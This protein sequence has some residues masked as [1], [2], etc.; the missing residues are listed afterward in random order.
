[1]SDRIEERDPRAANGRGGVINPQAS[2]AGYAPYQMYLQPAFAGMKGDSSEDQVDTFACSD[3]P[4]PFGVVVG[5]TAPH[6]LT[7][8]PGGPDLVGVA[9]HD[10]IIASRGGY[11]Q[12]DAVSVMT[13]GRVWCQV[14]DDAGADAIDDGIYVMY[15]PTNG[16]VSSTA[17]TVV[18]NAV[19]KGKAIDV[20]DITYTATTKIA[21]VELHYPFAV[22]GP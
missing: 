20:Y 14:T 19:F 5:R 13:R 10:H 4:I 9:L 3:R 8:M 12:F 16:F 1:M 2:G 21:L 11:T 18:P 17:G 6:L 22:A 7:I 15:D